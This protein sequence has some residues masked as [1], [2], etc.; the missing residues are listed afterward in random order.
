MI[1][2]SGFPPG[3]LLTPAVRVWADGEVNDWFEKRPVRGDV[4]DLRGAPRRRVERLKAAQELNVAE[5]SN[6]K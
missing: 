1:S 4:T 3:R 5:K 2:K 6:G